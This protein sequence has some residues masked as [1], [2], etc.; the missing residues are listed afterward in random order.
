MMALVFLL[1]AAL[2]YQILALVSLW[3]FFQ[4]PFP[5]LASAE[6]PGITIFKPVRGLAPETRKCLE[7]FLAQD[8]HP[9]QVLFGVSDPKDPVV[10]LLETLRQAAPPGRVEVMLCPET[11]GHNP[12]VSILRQLE[13]QARYD[14]LVVADGDVKVGPDFLGWVAAAFREPQVGLV[15]CPYRAGPADSLGSWLEA[16]SISADFIPSVAVAHSV[17]GIRFALGAAMAFTRT[18]LGR[19]GGFAALADYLADDYQLGWQ[20]HQAGFEV[21]LLPYVVETVNPRMRL[22]DYLSHQLRWTR[23]YRVCRPRG[24]F[25]YGITHALVFSLSLWLISGL[26]SWALGLVAA[27]LALRFVL[28]WFSENVCLGGK[29]SPV[30]L[31]ILPV[32]D[33]LSF[34]LWLASFLGNEVVWQGRRYRLTREGLLVPLRE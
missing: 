33:L 2:A 14:L 20:V 27:T 7:S 25:A 30:A 15:S 17:E 29:L 22:R 6:P 26:A 16:L 28:A 21:R 34:G 24:Y 23:T 19:I 8:Y 10:P 13:T 3:R 4:K 18:A 1:L 5:R 32:K 31:I 12:K 9:Y 11:L